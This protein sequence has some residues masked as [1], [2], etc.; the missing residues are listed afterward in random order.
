[1]TTM[2]SAHTRVLKDKGVAAQFLSERQRV[3][4]PR[5]YRID[6]PVQQS[7]DPLVGLHMDGL[8]VRLIDQ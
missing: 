1:M 6:L 4:R 5:A 8:N 7:A 2:P 3:G